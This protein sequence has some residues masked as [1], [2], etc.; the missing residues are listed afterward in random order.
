MEQPDIWIFIGSVVVLTGLLLA[1]HYALK[2]RK[3]REIGDVIN[4][5]DVEGDREK[6]F[7]KDVE[8]FTQFLENIEHVEFYEDLLLRYPSQHEN[9][10]ENFKSLF[11]EDDGNLILGS[12]SDYHKHWLSDF[13]LLYFIWFI[14]HNKGSSIFLSATTFGDALKLYDKIV[15]LMED[16]DFR[17]LTPIDVETIRRSDMVLENGSRLQ[18]AAATDNNLRGRS[19]D[20]VYCDGFDGLSKQRQEDFVESGLISLLTP[21]CIPHGRL[22]LTGDSGFITESGVITEDVW[23]AIEPEKGRYFI[24]R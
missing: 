18:V 22:I 19:F 5:N 12:T 6:R 10:V 8:S 3:L 14:S 17:E 16:P 11:L 24:N 1:G 2:S 23:N 9:W 21:P 15:F 20:I 4:G 13:T 7:K